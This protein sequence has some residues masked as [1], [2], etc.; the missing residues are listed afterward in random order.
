MV[1]L[2]GISVNLLS[3]SR[4]ATLCLGELFACRW[5]SCWLQLSGLFGWICA[6]LDGDQAHSP[7][8][9]LGDSLMDL[10]F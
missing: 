3:V 9:Q 6:M 8:H 5:G 10:L 2:A 7:S 4:W 1:Y